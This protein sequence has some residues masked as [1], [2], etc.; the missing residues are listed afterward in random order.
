MKRIAV[1]RLLER[2]GIAVTQR[3]GAERWARCPAHAPDKSPSWSVNVHTGQHHCFSCGWGGGAA[4]LVIRALDADR[5][6]WT[7][8]D[9]MAWLDAHGFFEEDDPAFAVQLVLASGRPRGFALPAEVRVGVPFS[10]WP[11]PAMA[12]LTERGVPLWQVAKWRVGFA[13]DGRLAH[14]IVFVL[15][16]TSGRDRSY[17][18]R[19]F[20]DGDHA[21]YLTPRKDERADPAA[22][23][24]EEHWPGLG[25]RRRVVVTEGA[26]DALAVERALTTPQHRDACP[27]AGMLGA[28]R[29]EALLVAAK[30]ATFD[31]VVVMTD[32]DAAGDAA[33]QALRASL[34]RHCRV[35]R[36]R[37]AEG[38][39]AASSPAPMVASAVA[40]AR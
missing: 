13:V 10:D 5:L 21:R 14:R 35:T 29:A 9:A 24:G 8:A 19:T 16:D 39:D 33:W 1:E 4:A 2:L 7:D 6:A 22:L 3:D 12:Y 15:R 20:L 23:F 26:L 30:L 11:T 40:A 31:E 38:S 27:V 36:A 25:S 17:S 32:P 18:A 37:L 28:T 34:V